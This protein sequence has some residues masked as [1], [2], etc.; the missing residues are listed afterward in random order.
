M[1]ISSLK[2]DAK[3]LYDYFEEKHIGYNF[4][5]RCH[6]CM[7]SATW[8]NSWLKILKPTLWSVNDVAARQI[9]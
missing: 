9:P 3:Y 7:W 2:F 6:F 1:Y 8:I 5:K 4:S